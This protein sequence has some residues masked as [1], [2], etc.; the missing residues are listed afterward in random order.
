[1]GVDAT[2]LLGIVALNLRRTEGYANAT[3]PDIYRPNH[4]LF[5]ADWEVGCVDD[6]PKR[7]TVLEGNLLPERCEKGGCPWRARM[8]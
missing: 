7:K 5:C 2:R 4:H 8:I 1:M 3:L 6:L